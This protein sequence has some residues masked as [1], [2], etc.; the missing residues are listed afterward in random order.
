MATKI[1][2]DTTVFVRLLLVVSGFVGT[3][4]LIWQVW[5]ALLLISVSFFLALALNPSVSALSRR[6]PG[7]SRVLATL[8]AY[9]LILG[10]IGSF[11]YVAVPPTIDQTVHF[12]NNL[13]SYINNLR[14]QPGFV[15]SAV[16]DFISRYQLQDE[17]A[18]VVEGVQTQAFNS[19]GGIGGSVVA[20][21]SSFLVGL[22]TII[23]LLVLTFLMLIEGPQWQRRIF[24]LIPDRASGE[25]YSK[26]ATKMYGVVSSYV[27]GQLVVA[28]IAAT[29]G[30]VTLFTLSQIFTL[31]L[32]MILPLVGVIFITDMIP[33]IG[34]TIGAII[35]ILVLLF[36]DFGAA[37][38]FLIYFVIYQQIENNFIQP[39]VQARTVALSALSILI[40]VI[41][42]VSLLGI[43]GG[44]LAIPIAGCIRVAILDYMEHRRAH[45]L[46]ARVASIKKI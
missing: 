25:R 20:G 2:V 40:T 31:P 13:P 3:I 16:N 26:L 10:V 33:L 34:A 5:P 37:L 19:L 42:G 7:K 39:V 41:I 11:I 15:A 12:V 36:S 22:V 35:V 24:S 23:T 14:E 1:D 9:V 6:L 21:V 29:L 46:P 38:S 44:I 43:V 8:I 27:N 45:R 17:L 32:G 4:L 18:K 30:L 28:L